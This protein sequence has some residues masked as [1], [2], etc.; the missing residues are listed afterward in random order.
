MR[1]VFDGAV[2]EIGVSDPELARGVARLFPGARIHDPRDARP[3]PIEV[4]S[5]ADG[6]YFRNGE[7]TTSFDSIPALM[8]D[9]EFAV[10]TELLEH[11]SLHTHIHAAGAWTP[12]GAVL[13]T[14][15]AGA[16]KSSCA[17]AWSVSGLPLFGDDV[18]FVDSDGLVAPFPRLLKAHPD[19]L[20]EF[21]IDAADTP[22]WHPDDV[23]A[24]FEPEDRY[25]RT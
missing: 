23:E 8:A 13:V 5:Q 19:R 12:G 24:W 4:G 3:D 18:V 20:A 15:P 22:F 21:G 2:V 6:F 7:T 1:F 11:D 17:L 25:G 14:G 9:V 16:G 10:V